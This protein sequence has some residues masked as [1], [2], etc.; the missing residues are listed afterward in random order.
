VH[1]VGLYCIIKQLTLPLTM[2]QESD[3]DNTAAG[4]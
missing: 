2:K 4:K 3:T 1:S